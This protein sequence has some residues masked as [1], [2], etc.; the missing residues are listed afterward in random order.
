MN[1]VTL[2][3]RLTPELIEEGFANE[4]NSKC[5]NMHKNSIFTKYWIINGEEATIMICPKEKGI[6]KLQVTDRIELLI[7]TESESLISA[8]DIYYKSIMQKT[9]STRFLVINKGKIIRDYK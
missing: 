4:I 3:I 1:A 5:Q 9:L 2:D 7:V 6:S 8:V